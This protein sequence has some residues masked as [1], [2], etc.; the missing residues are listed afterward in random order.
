MTG[1][2]ITSLGLFILDD[3][4]YRTPS[5]ELLRKSEQSEIG[6]GGTYFLIGARIW[7]PPSAVGLLVDRG[8]DF[9]VQDRLDAYGPDCW[10]YRRVARKTTRALNLYTG[11]HRGTSI[12]QSE[13]RR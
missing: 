10:H 3:F 11:E 8:D 13:V 12:L 4:E 9:E 6:G 2:R 5:G 1:K 7:L